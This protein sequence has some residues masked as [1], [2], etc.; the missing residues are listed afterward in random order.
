MR[1]LILEITA[2]EREMLKNAF[3]THPKPHVRERAYALLKVSEGLRIEEV[4]NLL[5]L[6][7]KPETVSDWV[8]RFQQFGEA[9]LAKKGGSGRKPAF[10]PLEPGG[11]K[12][13]G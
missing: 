3:R 4:A 11:S 1:R 9:G 10:F 12:T 5:P 8:K 6:K 7:R 2:K 13:K